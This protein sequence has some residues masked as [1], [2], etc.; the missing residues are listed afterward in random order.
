MLIGCCA[1]MLS[2]HKDGTGIENIESIVKSGFDYVELPLAQMM[3]LPKSEFKKLEYKLNLNN[4]KC[5][6]CN[7]FFPE[8]IRL[9]GDNVNNDATNE[10]LEQALTLANVLGVKKIVFGSSGAK[11]V[12]VGFSKEKAFEQLVMLLQKA[13]PL[14]EQYGIKIV[15][16]PLNKSE[17]NIINTLKDG[18]NL[19]NAVNN[20][21]VR[22]LVD[23]YHF[24]VNME[25]IG[26]I[27]DAK[28][29]ISHVHFARNLRRQYPTDIHED[30][31]QPFFKQLKGINYN[32]TIS[33]E[34]YTD[35]IGT[36]A[37]KSIELLKALWGGTAL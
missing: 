22:L 34:A 17:S 15:I 8:S 28:S 7:N 33:I 23:Y 1:N 37:P 19:V 31:Y 14:V 2:C 16:E 32:D 26:D 35:D 11:N 13:A 4:I 27:S 21:S 18:M 29:Y 5:L 10:Y 6:V 3:A 9:T 36:N 24:S 30:D 12:P 20:Q 25:Y